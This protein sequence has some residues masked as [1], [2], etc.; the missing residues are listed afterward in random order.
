MR[1]QRL[2]DAHGLPAARLPSRL[3][4]GDRH[5]PAGGPG[6][7]STTGKLDG[8]LGARSQQQPDAA[9]GR[10]LAARAS[11][12]TATPSPPSTGVAQQYRH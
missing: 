6:P 5:L 8:Q 2:R 7:T 3:A 12:L 11:A 1:A 9:G 10:P 4:A